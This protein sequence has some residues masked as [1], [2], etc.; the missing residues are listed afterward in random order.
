MTNRWFLIR[1]ACGVR[2]IP[3]H[4]MVSI[5]SIFHTDNASQTYYGD[6]SGPSAGDL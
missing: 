4:C 3:F 5:A 6:S 1:I 2:D